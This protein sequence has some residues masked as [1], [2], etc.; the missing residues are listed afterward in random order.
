MVNV[1]RT[2]TSKLTFYLEDDEKI[3]SLLVVKPWF[4]FYTSETFTYEVLV[5]FDFA[6]PTNFHTTFSCN[7]LP[8]NILGNAKNRSLF[9]WI[10]YCFDDNAQY[11]STFNGGTVGFTR[12]SKKNFF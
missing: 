8:L 4:L 11:E 12:G 5:K 3:P 9:E 6:L 7:Q 10:T 1:I 2:D